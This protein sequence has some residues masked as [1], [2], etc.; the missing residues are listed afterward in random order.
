M[1]MAPPAPCATG[2]P[3][4]TIRGSLE[5]LSEAEPLILIRDPERQYGEGLELLVWI[6]ESGRVLQAEFS[7]DGTCVIQCKF[8]AWN[9]I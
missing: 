7:Q 1:D 2:T 8:S 6:E 4:M 5:A 3:S 9:M